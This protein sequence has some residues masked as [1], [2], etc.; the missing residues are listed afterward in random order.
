MEVTLQARKWEPRGEE[1]RPSGGWRRSRSCQADGRALRWM[2]RRQPGAACAECSRST[3]LRADAAQLA[4]EGVS[5]Q[6]GARSPSAAARRPPPLVA[7]S[8]PVRALTRLSSLGAALMPGTGSLSSRWVSCR[9]REREWGGRKRGAIGGQRASRRLGH[10][11]RDRQGRWGSLAPAHATSRLPARLENS[12]WEPRGVHCGRPL[13]GAQRNAGSA[14]SALERRP[15][16]RGKLARH[17]SGKDWLAPGL[18][19]LF[20]ARHRVAEACTHPPS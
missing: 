7:D 10:A 12:A 3:Q 2:A 15:R 14:R 9:G 18:L 1:E 8:Q 20:C 4:T 16:A 11:P 6:A 19:P 17:S 5:T 13:G